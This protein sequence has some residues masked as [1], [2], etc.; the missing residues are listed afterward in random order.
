[1]FA[2]I[3]IDHVC[4][5]VERNQV[6]WVDLHGRPINFKRSTILMEIMVT[7]ECFGFKEKY[8]AVQR[9]EEAVEKVDNGYYLLAIF[10]VIMNTMTK[11][12]GK[13]VGD[14]HIFV[15]QGIHFHYTHNAC[16]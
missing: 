5:F 13:K 14:K 7:I 4:A 3:L 9:G 11:A 6:Q 10:D 1:M 2:Q 16:S 12:N 15:L 8:E